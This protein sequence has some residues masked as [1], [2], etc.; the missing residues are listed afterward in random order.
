MKT[1]TIFLLLFVLCVM[2]LNA[3]QLKFVYFD[4]YEPYSFQE[5]GKMNGVL[6]DV[7]NHLVQ[8]Q[9]NLQVSHMGYPWKRAQMRVEFGKADGFITAPTPARKIYTHCTELA[10]VESQYY[11]FTRKDHP[12]LAKF[13]KFQTLEEAR[14]YKIVSY[15]GN[16]VAEKEL[17]DFKVKWVP[18]QDHMMS[19]IA[20]GRVD[21]YFGEIQVFSATANRGIINKIIEIPAPY[22]SRTGFHICIRKT[23]PYVKLI[24]KI[25]ENIPQLHASEEYH[26]IFD[27]Y[28][29]RY[30]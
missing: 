24:P 19:M 26:K 10:A 11:L 8:D 7:V 4:K 6:I 28:K 29:N 22:Y 21:I 17:K 13:K 18:K 25:N 2:P 15:I 3:Q 1:T 16:G 14:G 27:K 30:R 12:H 5:E 9:F 20:S 23:S